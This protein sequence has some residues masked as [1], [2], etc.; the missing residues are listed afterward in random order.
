MSLKVTGIFGDVRGKRAAS[1]VAELG[2]QG[3]TA[4]LLQ[5][6]P[7]F[8]QGFP[9]RARDGWI[10]NEDAVHGCLASAHRGRM[11]IR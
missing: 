7:R 1:T 3:L 10:R 6:P 4:R 9:D 5:L 2:Q 8:L 11:P